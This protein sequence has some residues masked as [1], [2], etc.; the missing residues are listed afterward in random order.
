MV[1]RADIL[2]AS[3]LKNMLTNVSAMDTSLPRHKSQTSRNARKADADSS[4]G[5]GV[6]DSGNFTSDCTIDCCCKKGI[7]N[8]NVFIT[9]DASCAFNHDAYDPIH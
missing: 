8:S 7:M 9:I 1:N 6:M 4:I 2:A 3:G 5:A